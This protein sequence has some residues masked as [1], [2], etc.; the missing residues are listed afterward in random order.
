MNLL[1]IAKAFFKIEEHIIELFLHGGWIILATA[2]GANWIYV[3]FQKGYRLK[4]LVR[5]DAKGIVFGKEGFRYIFSPTTAEGHCVIF[6]GSGLGKT[7]ALL[8]P[9]LRNW[10]GTCICIDISGDINTNVQMPNM[11]IYEPANPNSTPYNVFGEIDLLE[12][13]SDKDEALEQLA[14]LLMPENEN[15]SDA[16][17]FFNTQGRKILTA[18]L[19]AFYHENMDFIPICER[20]IKSGWQK[21]FHDI[22]TSG[23]QKAIDYINSFE[24]TLDTN[25]SGCKQSCDEAI[26]LFANIERIK[27]TIRRPRDG[28]L[29]FTPRMLE[30]HNVFIVIE[31]SKM[32]LYSPLLHIITSQSLEY[33][34]KRPNNASNTILFCLDEFASFGRMDGFTDGLRKLRKKNVRIIAITQSMADIDLTYGSK[35]ERQAMLNNFS[36]KVVLGCGDV[37]TQEYF[38]KLIGEHKGQ[39]LGVSKNG[40]QVTHSKTEERERIVPPEKLASLGDK[41]ILLTS[42]GHIFLRKN[43][44]FKKDWLERLN[45]LREWIQANVKEKEEDFSE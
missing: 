23:Y 31:D 32:V 22:D 24:G 36:F 4:T 19:I 34:S 29:C 16:S 14:F 43:Y 45:C 10:S 9:T 37:D 25:T 3:K 15:L 1:R 7:S 2:W 5:T 6:G 26:K 30:S 44:Y 42:K 17:L 40:K 12:S 20:I 11:L 8:I 18:A 33:C 39:K 35:E 41:L 38:S 28:E 13:D 27:K 21:L